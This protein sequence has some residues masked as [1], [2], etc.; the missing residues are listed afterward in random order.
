LIY[1]ISKDPDPRTRGQ[2]R[3]HRS[4]SQFLCPR[5]AG[6]TSASVRPIPLLHLKR[7]V[8]TT[9]EFSSNLA[10][11]YLNILH[12]IATPGTTFEGKNALCTGVGKG[13]IGVEVV[14]GFL[15]GG[16]RIVIITSSYNHKTVE[17]YQ[18]IFQSFGGRGSA[19]TVV[20]FIRASR[21]DVEA[22]INYICNKLNMDLDY[23]MPFAGIS[24]NGREIHGLDD[25][26]E[27][28]HELEDHGVRTFSAKEMAFNVLGLMHPFF[29]L[30]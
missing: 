12:E 8:G 6:T 24:E 11:V 4:S 23:I 17:Y 21:Q 14:K 18:S 20:P 15:S 5:N 9:R 1:S 30:Q 3:N 7:K 2:P 22:L 28:A 26:S 16:A 29:T 10:G 25:R 27:L 19:L 13:S